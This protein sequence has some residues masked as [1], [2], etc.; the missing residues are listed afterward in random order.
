MMNGGLSVRHSDVNMDTTPNATQTKSSAAKMCEEELEDD[1]KKREEEEALLDAKA[2]SELQGLL[3]KATIK[4]ASEK[5]HESLNTSTIA[6]DVSLDCNGNIGRKKKR[7][8]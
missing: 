4:S 2:D 8:R 6:S 5:N 7:S 1:M 3:A